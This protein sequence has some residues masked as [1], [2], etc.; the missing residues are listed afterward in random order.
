MSTV[1]RREFCEGV[2]ASL[3]LLSGGRGALAAQPRPSVILVIADEMRYQSTGYAGDPN[4][5]TPSIDR[6]AASAINFENAVAGCPVCCP[7]R[8]SLL[9]GQYPLTNG[10]Y[11]NDVPLAPKGE[12]LAEAFVSAGYRTGY[13]GKWHLHGSPE[14]HWERRSAYIPPDKRFGFSYWKALECTHDYNHSL[15][16]ADDDP[17]PR[18]WPGY[19]AI[20]QTKD[21]C[22]FIQTQAQA[23]APYFLVL[24]W[25]EPHFAIPSALNGAPARFAARYQNLQL[26][27]RPNVPADKAQAAVQG[28]RDYYASISA[29]DACFARLLSTL[30]AT[31]TADDTIVVF[32]S[33]HGDMMYSQGLQRKLFPWEESIRVP[34]LIRYPRRFGS[35][36]RRSPALVNFPDIMPTLLGLCGLPIPRGVQGTDFSGDVEGRGG[37]SP[38]SAFL[39]MPVPFVEMR[40]AGIAEYRGV[41]TARYSYVRSIQGPWLLYDNQSDPYQM[42]NLIGRPEAREV[43]AALDDELKRWLRKLDDEFLP[44]SDYLRRDGLTHYLE[45]KVPIGHMRSPWGD[46]ESTLRKPPSERLS[47]DSALWE[48]LA[49]PPAKAILDRTLP[50]LMANPAPSRY[51]QNSLRILVYL[52]PVQ[53]PKARL[54]AI[55]AALSRLPPRPNVPSAPPRTR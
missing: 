27:L 9:T 5:Q 54:E 22:H 39:S 35:T 32:L 45:P 21:A 53:N 30:E 2:I 14:G 7:S 46:W 34:L 8:A 33:D 6:F 38:S 18:M 48:L 29:L 36:G 37:G 17:A 40:T 25:G 1:S 42:H 47:I 13:I 3:A 10:V 55:D 19:D 31:G 20:A 52:I 16:Y 50:E 11:I 41:R 26:S 24:S 49:D 15:Y 51:L 28:L 4:A 23:R 12:T 44:A 43:Q